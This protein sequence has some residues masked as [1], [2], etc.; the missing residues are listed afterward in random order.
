MRSTYL[1]KLIEEGVL[2]HVLQGSALGLGEELLDADI[3]L[4]GQGGHPLDPGIVCGGKHGQGESGVVQV[5]C[6]ECKI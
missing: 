3:V 4:A 5:V 2:Q 6:K 1:G